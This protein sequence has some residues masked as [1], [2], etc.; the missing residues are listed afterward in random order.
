MV[1]IKKEAIGFKKV[2]LNG[3]SSMYNIE[4]DL[5]LGVGKTAVRR[6]LYACI[7]CIGKL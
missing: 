2:N 3:T 5:D 6:V 4:L 7:S 1:G